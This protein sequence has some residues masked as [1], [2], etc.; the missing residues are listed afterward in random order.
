MLN[1]PEDQGS[2]RWFLYDEQGHQDAA[3]R[4]GVP[5]HLIGPC[6]LLLEQCSPYIRSIRHAIS[7]IDGPSYEIH[8]QQPVAGGEIAAIVNPYNLQQI[9]GRKI[10]VSY[11][12]KHHPDFVDILS[13]MY[14]SLQY[15]LFFPYADLGWSAEGAKLYSPRRTQLQ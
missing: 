4:I 15:P 13:P 10:V 1:N 12:K 11:I 9:S 2:L 5:A 14:E 3:S 6:K 8:L 7:T